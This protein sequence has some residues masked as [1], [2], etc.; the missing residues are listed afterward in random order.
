MFVIGCFLLFAGTVILSLW[1]MVVS[2]CYHDNV[3]KIITIGLISSIMLIIAGIIL[4]GYD[5]LVFL[6]ILS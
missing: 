5:G 1:G 4:I 2:S 6:G 3:E